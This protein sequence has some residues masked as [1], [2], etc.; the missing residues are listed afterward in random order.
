MFRFPKDKAISLKLKSK[1]LLSFMLSST[2][3][4]LFFALIFYRYT[5][6]ALLEQSEQAP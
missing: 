1:L 5:S 4:L 3:I 6:N 2:L